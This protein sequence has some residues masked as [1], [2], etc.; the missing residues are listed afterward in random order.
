MK[1]YALLVMSGLSLVA[2]ASSVNSDYAN[3][4]STQEKVFTLSFNQTMEQSVKVGDTFL[5]EMASNPSTG[6]RW[7]LVSRR[8]SL[9]CLQLKKEQ[10]FPASSNSQPPIVGAPGKQQWQ[11]MAKC[12][13]N[14]QVRFEYRR[15]WESTSTPAPIQAQLNL[16]IQ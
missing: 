8:E 11:F 15:S 3:S 16:R 1:S 6:Y 10:A 12:A 5:V 2:C 13:G 14:V 4:F 7:A 9:K